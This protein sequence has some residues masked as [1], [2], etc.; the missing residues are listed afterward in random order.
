MKTSIGIEATI[1]KLEHYYDLVS[2]MVGIA[3]LLDPRMKRNYLKNV[4]RWRNSWLES[5]DSHFVS[6]FQYYK[7]GGIGKQHQR[8]KQQACMLLLLP[9]KDSEL[10]HLIF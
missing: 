1:E 4:L 5:L 9:T 3:L 8:G 2:P 10:L 7:S 6:V